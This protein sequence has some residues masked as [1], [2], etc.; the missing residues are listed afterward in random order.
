MGRKVIIPEELK[1]K[2]YKLELTFDELDVLRRALS[3][4]E[5]YLEE[6]MDRIEVSDEDEL[7][8]ELIENHL[9]EYQINFA[10]DSELEDKIMDSLLEEIIHEVRIR[11]GRKWLTKKTEDGKTVTLSEQERRKLKSADFMFLTD[12]K[13]QNEQI[14]TKLNKIIKKVEKKYIII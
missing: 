14:V 1:Q 6:F 10:K 9:R 4:Y 7:R 8:L 5:S 11:K 2:K 12:Q 13:E 3:N